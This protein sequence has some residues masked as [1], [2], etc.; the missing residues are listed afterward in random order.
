MAW[1]AAAGHLA[2]A[3][4]AEA[5]KRIVGGTTTGRDDGWSGDP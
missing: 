4:A 3:N 2:E 1:A 5:L